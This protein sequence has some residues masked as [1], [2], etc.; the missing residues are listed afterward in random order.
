MA[1]HSIDLCSV[2]DDSFGPH[3]GNCRGGFD[4][5]LLFEETILTIVPLACLF[6]ASSLRLVYLSRQRIKLYPSPLFYVKLVS[7][8]LFL[9]TRYGFNILLI[10]NCQGLLHWLC[11]SSAS[12][13]SPLG[14]PANN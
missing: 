8:Y 13:C 7:I 3:A 9:Y 1:F 11:L 10:Y 4:F 5:T 6:F 12:T 14:W 2:V